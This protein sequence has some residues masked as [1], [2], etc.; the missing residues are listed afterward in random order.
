MIG[1]GTE[2]DTSGPKILRNLV[3]LDFCGT[4]YLVHPTGGAVAGVESYRAVS[5]IA[6]RID[7]AIVAVPEDRIR[8]VV[9]RCSS[10][11]VQ[12]AV[13]VPDRFTGDQKDGRL[14]WGE[15]VRAAHGG[16][17]RLVGPDS[18]GVVNTSTD[19][20]MNGT[21]VATPPS[22][23]RVAVALLPFGFGTAVMLRSRIAKS[24][25]RASS[26]WGTRQT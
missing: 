26:R 20:R 2:S 17:M 25:C 8:G 16:G 23:G 15:L 9:E 1:A 13:V 24:V 19:V 12:N 22:R 14:R 21:F 5:D 7:M 4:V 3:A 10:I 18:A 11:R 6:D